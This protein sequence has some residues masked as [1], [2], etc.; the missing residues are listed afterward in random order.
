MVE[1]GEICLED[2][3]ATL[4]PFRF[5][6][7]PGITLKQLVNH[8][9]GMPRLPSDFTSYPEYLD[10]NPYLN[11]NEKKF[12]AYLSQFTEL[13]SRPGERF[14]YSNLGYGVLS[15]ILATINKESFHESIE[16]YIFLPVEMQNSGFDRRK[17]KVN[18]VKGQD[19]QGVE[20][21]Y[22]DGGILSGCVGMIS[23]AADLS[24]FALQMLKPENDVNKLQLMG[25]AEIRPGVQICMGWAKSSASNEPEVFGHGGGTAGFGS[26]LTFSR[27]LQ[28]AVIILSNVAPDTFKE[29]IEPYARQLLV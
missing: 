28:T 15:Y 23:T 17:I 2:P 10:T 9:S 22:W 3:I 11:Y 24:A 14:I 13:E 16:K 27:E 20:T 25:L 21:P 18:M 5:H 1:K 26:V 19:Q 12:V 4:L 8:T 6:G 7:N 29:H